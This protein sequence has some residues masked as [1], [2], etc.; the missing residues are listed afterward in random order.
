PRARLEVEEHV[1]ALVMTGEYLSYMYC[2]RSESNSIMRSIGQ[3]AGVDNLRFQEVYAA[4]DSDGHGYGTDAQV[5]E[6]MNRVH[7]P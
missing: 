3:R 5:R 2:S 4:I 6:L 1:R 7:I